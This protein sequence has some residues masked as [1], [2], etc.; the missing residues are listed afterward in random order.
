MFDRLGIKARWQSG[1]AAACKAVDTGSTPVRASIFIR[2]DCW[3]D[4]RPWPPELKAFIRGDCQYDRWLRQSEL[5][6]LFVEIASRL[7]EAQI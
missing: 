1:Y 7:R 5:K 6:A 3:R 2:D 4:R